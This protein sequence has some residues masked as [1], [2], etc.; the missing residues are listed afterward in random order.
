MHYRFFETDFSR[1]KI[2]NFMKKVYDK[3]SYKNDINVLN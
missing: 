3:S 2:R 1:L